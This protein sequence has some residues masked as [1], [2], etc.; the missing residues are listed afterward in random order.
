MKNTLLSRYLWL[1]ADGP[2]FY[3]PCPHQVQIS[4]MTPSLCATPRTS[5]G[6]LFTAT[7]ISSM[8]YVPLETRN[9][10][11]VSV[12]K[13][14]NYTRLV[15]VQNKGPSHMTPNYIFNSPRHFGLVTLTSVFQASL[16][17]FSANTFPNFFTLLK[18]QIYS[19]FYF[20]PQSHLTFNLQRIEPWGRY[21]PC[22][23]TTNLHAHISPLSSD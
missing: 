20:L 3:S 17:F 18:L 6:C 13:K 9:L 21:S 4:F 2:L 14:P 12:S 23:P 10:A 15:W 19:S 16:T 7:V 22:F 8:T 5:G 11:T 1:L